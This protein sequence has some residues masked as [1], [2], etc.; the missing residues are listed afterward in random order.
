MSDKNLNPIILFKEWFNLASEK[1][2]NDP[3]AMCLS[4]ISNDSPHSRMVLLKDFDDNGFVFYTNYE[5]NKGKDIQSNPNVCLNFHWKS[6]L[7]QV[8]I[9]G[10]IEKVSSVTSDNYFNSRHYLSRVGAWASNQSSVLESRELLE[11]KIEEIKLKYPEGSAF[12]RPDYWGGFIVKPLKI[13]FWQDMPHRIHK[14]EIYE[15]KNGS[16]IYYNLYP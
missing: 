5:S 3:N 13:E 16:W 10:Q 6:L 11:R 14:R 12:P 9:E 2:I 1:E 7:R 15:L 8:R 4:T